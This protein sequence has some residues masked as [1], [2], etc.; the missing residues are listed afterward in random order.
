MV[1]VRLGANLTYQFIHIGNE[2]TPILIIDDLVENPEDLID[3]AGFTV[4]NGE[5]FQ[6]QKS[7]F[8]PGIRK[9]AP[10]SYQT[11][12]GQSLFSLLKSSL[13]LPEKKVEKSSNYYTVSYLEVLMSAFSIATTKPEY[14][15]PIQMLPHFDTPSD[16][17][18][19]MVHYLCDENHGGTSIYRHKKTGFERIT[20]SRHREYRQLL[21][22]QAIS[23]KLHI[24]PKYIDGD[25]VLFERLYSVEAKMNRAVIYPSNLLHSGN[26]RPSSGLC[27]TPESGRLTISSFLSLK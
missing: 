7:D 22:R 4:G 24:N 12:I 11:V 19:A 26:I 25:T 13:F 9:N 14:L 15:K 5:K 2:R 18:L 10:Q 23:E 16:N 20:E 21:K 27:S 1:E 3:L 17:Q 8:Y 6:H